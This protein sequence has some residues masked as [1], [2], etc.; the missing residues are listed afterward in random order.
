MDVRKD[1][2]AA[3]VRPYDTD[4]RTNVLRT[5]NRAHR[6][7]NDEQCASVHEHLKNAHGRATMLR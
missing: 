4:V 1:R 5:G 6:T 3:S 2:Y 7:V